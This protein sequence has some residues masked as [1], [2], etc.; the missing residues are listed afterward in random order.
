[1]KPPY[2]RLTAI[3]LNKGEI[4]WQIPLGEGPRN[5]PA[6][7]DLD[8]GPLGSLPA[9]S[10]WAEGGVLV[11]KSLLFT[12]LADVDELNERVARGSWLLALDKATG[13]EVGR[14][15]VDRHLHSSPMT[16]MFEGRQYVLIA[17][18]GRAE[19]AEVLAF[20]IPD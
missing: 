6:L 20:G 8:L 19:P 12:I 3:D 7:A 1:M 14:L 9:K 17:G 5:H 16:A 15:K 11:T 13:E 10:V 2:R 4:V 18:G